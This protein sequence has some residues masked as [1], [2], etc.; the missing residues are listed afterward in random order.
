MDQ[1]Q[2]F[3]SVH[4]LVRGHSDQAGSLSGIPSQPLLFINT[5]KVPTYLIYLADR[6]ERGEAH[7]YGPKQT[8][9][10]KLSKG[11]CNKYS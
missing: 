4:P 1:E 6:E 3:V 5:N 10:Y 8:D 7:R 2:V 11:I 9:S